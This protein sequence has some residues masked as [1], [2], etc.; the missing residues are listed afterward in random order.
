MVAEHSPRMTS[1][2]FDLPAAPEVYSVASLTG[3]IHRLLSR[4]FDGIKVAGEISGWK[5]WTSGHAYFTLKDQQAQ[6]RC[7]L[8]RN[9]LRYLRF[10]PQDGVAVIARGSVEVRAERGEYQF[11]VSGLEPQ[12]LGRLYELFEQLKEKL[13]AEGLFDE[14][15]KRALPA[16]PRRIGIVTSPKGAVIRD[17]LT[18]LGRRWPGLHIRL[19][20][21]PVQGS[22]SVE[23]IVAG[24]R[25]FS[26]SGWPEVVIVGRGGGSLEDLWSF[27]D[28]RVARAIASSSVPVV[29][30]VGHETDFTIADFAADL[31]A[32]TPSAAAELVV[33]ERDE[34][35]LRI[36]HARQR[37][38]RALHFRLSQLAR[39]LEQRGI[40]RSRRL[41]E[42]RINRAQQRTDELDYA[43]RTRLTRTLHLRR[44]RLQ[45]LDARLR[46]RDL[47]V[48]LAQAGER[49]RA[50][51]R[52]LTEALRRRVDAARR[53]HG[54][55][56][57]RLEALSPLRVLERGYS[58]V[59]TEDGRIVKRAADAPAGTQIRV[60]MHEGRLDAEVRASRPDSE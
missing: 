44:Q 38:S 50:A 26:D 57:S 21:T 9:N 10:K 33:P 5:V 27:N 23:G 60:R 29:S 13:R 24:L 42:L 20:P 16:Y 19:Y 32:P 55:L 41:L 59:Q 36:E 25:W 7:V 35:L 14:S 1:L 11:V 12:G 58:I 31:R 51:S 17:M 28:E 37:V 54:P 56:A 3:E 49:L 46:A 40:E 22:G 48:R 52:A 4:N 30:A 47:R 39:R 45:Q 6:I 34:I 53:E 18:V 2:P 15:I 8:F 43:L